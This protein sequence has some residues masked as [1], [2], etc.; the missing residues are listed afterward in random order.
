LTWVQTGN[1]SRQVLDLT[2][3]DNQESPD[4][5]EW[6]MELVKPSHPIWKFLLGLLA[7]LSMA[8]GLESG[9]I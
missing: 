9:T 4:I 3:D 7:I 8:W 1:D 2:E 5:Q 6:E